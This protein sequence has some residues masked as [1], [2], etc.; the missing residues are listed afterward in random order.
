MTKMAADVLAIPI[1][2]VGIERAFNLA[3]Q[4]INVNHVRLFSET[5][6]Q[7]MMLKCSLNI[8]SSGEEEF[9]FEFKRC[10]PKERELAAQI[11]IDE[12]DKIMGITL[13][14]F[15][16]KNVE[17]GENMNDIIENDSN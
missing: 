1:A 17:N 8:V 13:P 16:M 11:K 9:T 3:H 4:I 15:T 2:D 7:I 5:I 6:K 14:M 10:S 12:Q